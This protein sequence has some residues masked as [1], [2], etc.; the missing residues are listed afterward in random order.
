M[1]LSNYW[2][3]YFIVSTVSE[4]DVESMDTAYANSKA[5]VDGRYGWFV[6][7]GA[8]CVQFISLGITLLA[9]AKSSSADC[10]FEVWCS[11]YD[12]SRHSGD[13]SFHG[14]GSIGDA[15]K[16]IAGL[17]RLHSFDIKIDM[18]FVPYARCTIR[19]W[20]CDDVFTSYFNRTSMVYKKRR[21]CAW[22]HSQ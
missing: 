5:N 6:C 13:C 1:R 22:C 8:F 16:G 15:G 19:Y 18:T 14:D 21:A 17:T 11:T 3:Y 12:Y 4:K 10:D 20:C 9:R 2:W 7:L